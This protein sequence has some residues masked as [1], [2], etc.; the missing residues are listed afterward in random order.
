MP[1]IDVLLQGSPLRTDVGIVGFCTVLLIEGEK[2]TLVDVDH[3]GRR[4]ALLAALE[5][6]GLTPEDIDLTVMSHVHWDHS[7]NYD[8]FRHAPMLVHKSE[9][10]YAHHPHKNDWATPAWTGV[11]IDHHPD[12][13]E[14]EEGYEIEPGVQL[15]HTP[16]H[17]PGSMSVKVETDSGLA[18]VSGDVLHYSSV[19][20]TRKN[21][22]V[23]W[24]EI[25]TTQSIDRIV[26]TADVIYPAHDRPF[27]IA[28]I[29]I[30]YLEP[31]NLTIMGLTPDE[32][33]VTFE[34]EPRPVWLMPG[35]EDQSEAALN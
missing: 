10:I 28:R 24:N 2:R 26:G 30:E 17:S 9:R 33:R 5:K 3:V 16:G 8:L 12:I 19:A 15:I 20:L 32:P 34:K 6:R 31:T 35:I 21:P 25:Q 1:K 11:M 29:G 22:L 7:Q 13:Q 18:T 23:F 4:T 14:V 27:R